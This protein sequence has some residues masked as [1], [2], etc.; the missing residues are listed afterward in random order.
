MNMIWAR[1]SIEETLNDVKKWIT[2][3]F[4]KIVFLCQGYYVLKTNFT[5]KNQ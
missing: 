1:K 2:K 3:I 4:S 5:F